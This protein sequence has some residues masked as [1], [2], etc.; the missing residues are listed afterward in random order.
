MT[1]STLSY[2]TLVG[3][4]NNIIYSDILFKT[5]PNVWKKGLSNEL[6]TDYLVADH[7]VTGV[8]TVV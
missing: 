8:P 2:V 3:E 6:Y 5:L 1:I 7:E 4:N